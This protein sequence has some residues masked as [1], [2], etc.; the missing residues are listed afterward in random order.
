MQ[1]LVN[2]QFIPIMIQP[3]ISLEQI[4][5]KRSQGIALTSQHCL[6]F[7]KS[8]NKDLKRILKSTTNVVCNI[9]ISL[10][11]KVCF[12]LVI[13]LPLTIQIT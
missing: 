7:P 6:L 10:D 9:E 3:K 2:H 11:L 4:C 5:C 13:A 1:S 8:K 12:S